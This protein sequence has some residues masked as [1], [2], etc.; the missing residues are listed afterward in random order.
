MESAP[1]PIVTFTLNGQRYRLSAEAVDS[2]LAGVEPDSVTKHA[3][4]INGSWYP[5]MQ[6]FEAATG[7][8]RRDFISHTA[9]RHFVAL[10]YEVRGDIEPRPSSARP[11]S[12]VARA[13]RAPG[14]S[15]PATPVQEWHTEANVQAAVVTSLALSGWQLVSV[16]HTATR[17]RGVDIIATKDGL[18]LGVEVKGF[19]SRSYA[20]PARSSET[21]PTSPSTQAGHWYAQ[22][23]LAAMRLRGRQPGWRSVIA[24]PD[25][26][27]YRTLHEDT[28]TSLTAAGIEVW[29][30]DAHG[31]VS[32]Q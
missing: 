9:R 22:A 18:T 16:A 10:G 31:A 17:E 3:V 32:A 29:W 1:G 7:V 21:K 4:R 6:A 25:F 28:G 23:V 12:A 15:S 5:V 2:R 24:L 14:G 19:P 26:P 8:P 11:G 30:V 20:D 27:R 13:D